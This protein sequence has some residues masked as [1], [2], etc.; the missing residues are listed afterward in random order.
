MITH[1]ITKQTKTD[2]TLLI[3]VD[4]QFIDPYQKSVLKRLKKD[5]KVDGFRPGNVPD[6]IAERELGAERV[7]AEVLEEVVMHAYTRAAREL[8]LDTIAS[9]NISLK[10][11]VPYTELEFEAEVAIMPEVKIDLT[12]LSVKKSKVKVDPKEITETLE[13]LRK[14]SATKIASKSAIKNGDEVKFDFDG[15]RAGK[16]VDGASAKGH[17]LTI[18]E[19][20]FIP[21][22]EENMIGLK[23]GATKTFTVTFPKDYH[24][25]DLAAA[26]VEF[27]V[28]IHEINTS[29]LQKLND[30]WAKTVGPV[31]DLKAL[32]VEIAKSL[33][34]NKQAEI[35]KQFEN[36]VLEAA[37]KLAKFDAPSSLVEEQI[38]RLRSETEEN[39]RNSGLDIEKYLQLQGQKPEEF[40]ATLKTEAEKRV[41]IG[42]L[43]RQIIESE[44]VTVSD[45]EVETELAQMKAN[46]TDPK[47]Q[48]ELTHGHFKDDLRNHLLTTKAVA[49]LSV[50]ATK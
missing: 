6:K 5:L 33:E 44:K 21:G 13:N 17:V 27:T 39:L 22:F 46:Y 35:D 32:K 29:E 28:T 1:K 14:Q 12:K 26:D 10:K 7:Q 31:Q 8:K 49:I 3:S 25:K 45:A 50:A 41:K 48:E 16:P 24:A 9:P 18:G 38:A 4:A 42:L 40:E 36:Q 11:F 34:H 19:G 30:S 37:L 43:L 47:M 20:S 2:V 15:T 23:N